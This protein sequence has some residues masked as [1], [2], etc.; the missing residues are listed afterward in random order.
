MTPL[1]SRIPLLDGSFELE[2]ALVS[3]VGNRSGSRP[4]HFL[5]PVQDKNDEL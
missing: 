1:Y 4:Q 5:I 2:L 3:G